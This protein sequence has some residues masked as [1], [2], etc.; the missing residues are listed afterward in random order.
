VGAALVGAGGAGGGGGGAEG[1]DRASD[2]TLALLEQLLE[3]RALTSFRDGVDDAADLKEVIEDYVCTE[4]VPA[5][6]PIVV[7]SRPEGVRL[8]L[9]KRNIVIMLCAH[10]TMRLM[11]TPRLA[12]AAQSLELLLKALVP[13]HREAAQALL[14]LLPSLPQGLTPKLLERD[15]ETG[16]VRWVE[17][18][19]DGRRARVRDELELC[20]LL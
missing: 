7:T 14:R 13:K 6:H 11:R 19:R 9:Y 2:E 12:I 5:G 8:R 10:R 1:Q 3:M 20:A 4:L 15:D 16:L 18:V 17:L